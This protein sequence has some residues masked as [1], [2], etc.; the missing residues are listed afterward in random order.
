[1]RKKKI[2]KFDD[3]MAI[4]TELFPKG[5]EV[6]LDSANKILMPKTV[7]ERIRETIKLSEQLIW[8]KPTK[9]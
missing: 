7:A 2:I 6:R 1:M 8:K 9:N 3:V 5:K 4:Y